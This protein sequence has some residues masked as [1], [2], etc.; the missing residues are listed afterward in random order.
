MAADEVD[1]RSEEVNRTPRSR[2][3]AIGRFSQFG[4]AM[5]YCYI[6]AVCLNE[7]LTHDAVTIHRRV[8]LAALAGSMFILAFIR[9][10][11][12]GFALKRPGAT[13]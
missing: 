3:R 9:L 2:W 1:E 6:G 12:L 10:M 7:V 4:L 8:L 5:G 13:Y 11:I